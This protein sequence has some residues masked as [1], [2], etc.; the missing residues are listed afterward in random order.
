MPMKS[1]KEKITTAKSST[2][3]GSVKYL[4]GEGSS[5]C[6]AP[7]SVVTSFPALTIFSAASSAKT[8]ERL[9]PTAS[10]AG[11]PASARDV[12]RPLVTVTAAMQK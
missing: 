5:R 6:F 2:F 9:R 11:S 10:S 8:I 1:E 12:S 7:S 3:I 4:P